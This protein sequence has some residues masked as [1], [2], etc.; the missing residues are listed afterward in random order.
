[1]NFSPVIKVVNI[2]DF[3]NDQIK[4]S[5]GNNAVWMIIMLFSKL[6]L[7]VSLCYY[8]IRIFLL[9]FGILGYFKPTSW[10]LVGF[11]TGGISSGT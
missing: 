4:C 3:F 7:R 8:M 9:T 10:A 1:M 2:I 6:V 11:D 5:G